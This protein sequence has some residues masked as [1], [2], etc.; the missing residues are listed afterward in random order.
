MASPKHC[1]GWGLGGEGVVEM[2]RNNTPKVEWVCSLFYTDLREFQ[3]NWAPIIHRGTHPLSALNINMSI[4]DSYL[5]LLI[6]HFIVFFVGFIY[7]TPSLPPGTIFQTNHLHSNPCLRL[8]SCSLSLSLSLSLSFWREVGGWTQGLT[9]ARQELC[10]WATFP[11]SGCSL[12]RTQTDKLQLDP[13]TSLCQVVFF[14]SAMCF[15]LYQ[16]HLVCLEPWLCWWQ[17]TGWCTVLK[18]ATWKTQAPSPRV[19][20]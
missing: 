13:E 12:E 4:K 7:V 5:L 15:L 1:I 16:R 14:C 6:T 10:H 2:G 8:C 18:N 19:P 17:Y 9:Y 11:V 3:Q 20:L